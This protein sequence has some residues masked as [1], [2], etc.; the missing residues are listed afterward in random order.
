MVYTP[1]GV[2]NLGK[3]I[4]MMSSLFVRVYK[5]HLIGESNNEYKAWMER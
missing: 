3:Y 5:L 1:F 4:Q 2:N